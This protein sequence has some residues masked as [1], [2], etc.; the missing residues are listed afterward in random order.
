MKALI[1]GLEERRKKER[2]NRKSAIIKAARKLFF[3]KGFKQVTVESIAKKA[4]LSKGAIY[5][6]YNSKEEIYAQILVNDLGKFHDRVSDL[7]DNAPSASDAL[8]GFANIYVD[9]SLNESELFRNLMNFMIHAAEMRLPSSLFNESIKTT[10]QTM[11]IIDQ[12]LKYGIEQGEFSTDI[13][14]HVKRN[15]VWGMLNGIICLYL[16]T[17]QEDKRE[18]LIKG[19][20]KEGMETFLKGLKAVQTR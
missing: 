9:F 15:A 1:M 11:G 17:G 10:N 4:E 6:H 18:E 3:E 5:L 13:N 8:L 12:I 7:L 20:V 16:F 14:Y 19:T 2:G